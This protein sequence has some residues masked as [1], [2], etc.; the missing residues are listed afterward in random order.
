MDC[1]N[2]DTW[3]P[4]ANFAFLKSGGAQCIRASLEAK[5][6]PW[7]LLKYE[8]TFFY[9]SGH[10]HSDSDLTLADGEHGPP[11][12]GA[13]WWTT[14]KVCIIS[15]CAV[16]NASSA[17]GPGR[18]WMSTGATLFLGYAGRGPG[19]ER[20][21]SHP[22]NKGAT[23]NII[24]AWVQARSDGTDPAQLWCDI[25]LD[26]RAKNACAIDLVNRK[27]FWIKGWD[28]NPVI[29]AKLFASVAEMPL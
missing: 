19:D 1:S 24:Q 3:A 29:R 28:F 8:A 11:S 18:K 20:D 17:T 16:L 15:G 4:A 2:E 10:G 6:S 5:Q 13:P 25:N 27:Y 12:D 22:D 21:P 9:H 26:A 23:S 7:R 14:L